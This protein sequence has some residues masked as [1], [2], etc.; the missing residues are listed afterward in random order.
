MTII[1]A[2]NALF[3][4]L[5]IVCRFLQRL[6][7]LLSLAFSVF[8]CFCSI[9]GQLNEEGED[10]VKQGKYS[11]LLIGRVRWDSR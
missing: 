2:T 10:V 6:S 8:I 1:L 11:K 9:M 4:C 7:M 3:S 5:L